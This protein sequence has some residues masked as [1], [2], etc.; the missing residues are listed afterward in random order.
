MNSANSSLQ[1]PSRTRY[2]GQLM[3]VSSRR[4]VQLVGGPAGQSP[5]DTHDITVDYFYHVG[6]F[7]RAVFPAGCIASVRGQAFNFSQVRTR[8]GSNG[9][10][11]IYN[12]Q[13]LPKRTLPFLN[14][15]QSRFTC[16]PAT[17]LRLYHLGE[18]PTGEPVH[19][20]T[21]FVYSAEA[22]GPAG[23]RF[24]LR[25]ALLSG[26]VTAHRFVSTRELVFERIVI[27]GQYLTESPP[28]PIS[29]QTA[30]RLLHK[31][32]LRSHHAG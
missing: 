27:Q 4:S 30:N 32:L 11:V 15:V 14:H 12:K 23:V 2:A 26:F 20:I 29:R 5:D 28:L 13:G 17:P 3:D 25:D 19:E 1:M 9:P 10:E 18:A 24:N 22:V 21:D 31:S 6:Q 8:K 7:W 16:D